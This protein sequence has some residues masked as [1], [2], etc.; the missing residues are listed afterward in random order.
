MSMDDFSHGDPSSPS[1]LPND[2]IED[3]ADIDIGEKDNLGR[4]SQSSSIGG[5][6]V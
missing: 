4:P 5:G 6:R 3:V 1:M 2:D